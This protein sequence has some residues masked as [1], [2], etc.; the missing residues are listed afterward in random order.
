MSTA[1][2]HPKSCAGSDVV[3]GCPAV[4]HPGLSIPPAER[5]QFPCPIFG[6]MHS[7]PKVLFPVG[8]L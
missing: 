5:S 8:W 4:R 1:G 7:H 3:G 6:K 2:H